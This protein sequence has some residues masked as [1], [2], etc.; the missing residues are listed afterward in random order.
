MRFCHC[1]TYFDNFLLLFIFNLSQLTQTILQTIKVREEIEIKTSTPSIKS[2]KSTSKKISFGVYPTKIFRM[3][4]YQRTLFFTHD[5][6]EILKFCFIFTS[7]TKLQVFEIFINFEIR[8]CLNNIIILGLVS[9]AYLEPCQT[10]NSA[11][12]NEVFHYRF[13]Q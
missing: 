8:E 7:L 2:K 6:S 1:D 11:Q 10:S 5:I 13:L 9:E 4:N 12:K 3:V